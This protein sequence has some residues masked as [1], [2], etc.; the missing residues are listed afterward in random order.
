MS[1]CTAQNVRDK[2]TSLLSGVESQKILDKIQ[3]AQD[4]VDGMLRSRYPVPLS[5]VPYVIVNITAS[6]AA[7]WLIADSVGNSGEDENPVQA[8][9]LYNQAWKQLEAIQAGKM[10][11]DIPEPVPPVEEKSVLKQARCTTYGQTSKFR[12]WDPGNPMSYR[13]RRC[14][15]R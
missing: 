14:G 1:Y 2:N 3:E 9:N 5:S 13:R 8:D 15:R 10:V 4:L 12:N 11:L 6:I 7:S